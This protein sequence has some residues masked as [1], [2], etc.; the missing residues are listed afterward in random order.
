[1]SP[2]RH[3]VAFAIISPLLRSLLDSLPAKSR[4]S[5]RLRKA[6]FAMDFLVRVEV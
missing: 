6:E 1:L 2:L 3:K 4:G 5:S